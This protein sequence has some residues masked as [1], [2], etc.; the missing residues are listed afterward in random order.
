MVRNTIPTDT[1]YLAA[2]LILLLT[3]MLCTL[4]GCAHP[5]VRAVLCVPLMND[6]S[7]THQGCVDGAPIAVSSS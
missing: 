1:I 7:L 3:L 2:M 4:S 5:A 6:A